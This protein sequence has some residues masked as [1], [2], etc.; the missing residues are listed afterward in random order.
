MASGKIPDALA[1]R[2]PPSLSRVAAPLDTSGPLGKTT[3]TVFA[4][5][6]QK[7]ITPQGLRSVIFEPGGLD[8][9]LT[10]S[11]EGEQFAQAPQADDKLPGAIINV[12][13]GEGSAKGR[14]F[15]V[16]VVLGPDALDAVRQK[17]NEQLQRWI[18][19]RT[20]H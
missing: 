17:G 20:Y 2:N 4:E 9:D 8:S 14:P 11:R 19:G 7:E 1:I 10:V 16:R 5:S 6:L 18:S 15:P 12:V 3:A 13:K